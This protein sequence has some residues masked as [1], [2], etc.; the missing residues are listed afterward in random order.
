MFKKFIKAGEEI[1]CDYHSSIAVRRPSDSND[2]IDLGKSC[3]CR[4]CLLARIQQDDE[5]LNLKKRKLRTKA[6]MA[7]PSASSEV[8]QH[9]MAK[10]FDATSPISSQAVILHGVSPEDRRFNILKNPADKLAGAGLTERSWRNLLETLLKA[11]PKENLEGGGFLQIGS[12]CGIEGLLTA[13]SNIGFSYCLSVLPSKEAV[14]IA[15]STFRSALL[16]VDLPPNLGVL[17]QACP[18]SA[19]QPRLDW[20]HLRVTVLFVT[21][22]NDTTPDGFAMQQGRELLEI[23]P[24]LRMVITSSPDLRDEILKRGD[25]WREFR[26]KNEITSC[27]SSKSGIKYPFYFLLRTPRD[28]NELE[29]LPPTVCVMAVVEEL[30]RS[31]QI[32]ASQLL[33]EMLQARED[34]EGTGVGVL[35]GS[36][37]SVAEP[38]VVKK[39][40]P[41]LGGKAINFNTSL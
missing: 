1:L 5:Q 13:I 15:T 37:S 30:H 29:P 11:L 36:G 18:I 28:S 20:H 33:E 27:M 38:T 25:H 34:K 40:R 17:K 9:L 10:F 32:E 2:T 22:L 7:W 12:S 23:L 4:E 6:E 39:K 35:T 41:T 31:G 21:P 16:D 14:D 24:D 8:Y 26:L 3:S 19:T